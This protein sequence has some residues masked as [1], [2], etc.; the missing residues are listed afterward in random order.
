MP[1]TLLKEAPHSAQLSLSGHF[2]YFFNAQGKGLKSQET[3]ATKGQ[4]SQQSFWQF[5]GARKTKFGSWVL[6]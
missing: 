4:K 3:K 5:H 2:T 6:P 1:K